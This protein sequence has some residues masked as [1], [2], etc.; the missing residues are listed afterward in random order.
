MTFLNESYWNLRP[1]GKLRAILE[2]SSKDSF[3]VVLEKGLLVASSTKYTRRKEVEAVHKTMQCLYQKAI[4][5]AT[6]RFPR[7]TV[8]ALWKENVLRLVGSAAAIAPGLTPPSDCG[9][10]TVGA[11]AA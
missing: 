3:L 5:L 9:L 1:V 8:T 2:D 6:L 11:L 7:G 4:V 10:A